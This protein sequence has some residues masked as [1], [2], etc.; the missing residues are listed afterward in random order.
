MVAVDN[1]VSPRAY[2]AQTD[3]TPARFF[4][5]SLVHDA[6]ALRLLIKVAGAT[7]VCLGSDYPFPLGEREPGQLI[8]SMDDL[9]AESKEAMLWKSAAEFLALGITPRVSKDVS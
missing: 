9:S 6:D 2:L 8:E 1:D 3:G 5:D 7:R 4:F